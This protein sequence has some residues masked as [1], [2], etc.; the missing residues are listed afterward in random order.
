MHTFQQ[1]ICN[2]LV[3]S[4]HAQRRVD[5]RGV[6]QQVIELL[7]KFGREVKARGVLFYVVGKKEVQQSCK[8]EP[9]L[10]DMEGMQVLTSEDGV[11]ITTYR[12]KHLRQIRHDN[13]R[14]R[15]YR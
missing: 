7:L 15:H 10:K 12:N 14:L 13:R 4:H 2:T 9:A 5:M 3:I 1:P 8:Q 6:N 11:I